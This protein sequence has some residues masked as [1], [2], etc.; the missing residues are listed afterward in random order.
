M[1]NCGSWILLTSSFGKDIYIFKNKPI[2]NH[3]KF[4][5]EEF[6]SDVGLQ[7]LDFLEVWMKK[8]KKKKRDANILYDGEPEV[9]FYKRYIYIRRL[10]DYFE[11]MASVTE[12]EKP[13]IFSDIL[14]I[15]TRNNPISTPY[16]ISSWDW[17]HLSCLQQLFTQFCMSNYINLWNNE[18]RKPFNS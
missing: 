7:N 16:E 13:V 10:C 3:S 14:S 17:L 6:E 9:I 12:H 18:R 4:C 5:I 15:C 1:V 8:K 2:S 11:S